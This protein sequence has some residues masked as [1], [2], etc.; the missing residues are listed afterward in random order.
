MKNLISSAIASLTSFVKGIQIARLFAVVFASWLIFGTNIALADNSDTLGERM[1]DRI[2]EVE[3]GTERAKTTREM[4]QEARPGLPLG[5]RIN[6][7]TRDSKEAFEQFGK[8]Y[9]IGAE[10]STRNVQDKAAQAVDD[11]TK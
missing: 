3:Q 10:E 5:E 9:T 6:R 2:N 7:I 1:R 11:I 4:E 8:E